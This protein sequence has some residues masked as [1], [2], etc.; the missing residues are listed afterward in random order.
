MCL[1]D[2]CT[3]CHAVNTYTRL[4][5][6]YKN[7]PSLTEQER[8]ISER[9][10]R[11][12]NRSQL[13]MEKMG[14]AESDL[15]AYSTRKSASETLSSQSVTTQLRVAEWCKYRM[16]GA[17][18]TA[19]V[20]TAGLISFR[21]GNSQLG[22]KLMRARVVVQGATVALMVKFRSLYLTIPYPESVNR[23][24]IGNRAMNQFK[25]IYIM[26][27]RLINVCTNL[28]NNPRVHDHPDLLI[29]N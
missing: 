29:S 17:F 11:A 14:A 4:R 13:V 10:V 3:A 25:G 23:H 18:I 16:R 22:Q 28:E 26:K 2:H 27:A 19:G 21:Q 15:K 9:V 6:N 7:T 20:L 1:I 5:Q 24:S 8:L 12:C